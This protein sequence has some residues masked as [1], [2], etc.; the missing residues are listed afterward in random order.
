MHGLALLLEAPR[1]VRLSR[2]ALKT[3]TPWFVAS[4]LAGNAARGRFAVDSPVETAGSATRFV[5]EGL[6]PATTWS[7]S[8]VYRPLAERRWRTS[9]P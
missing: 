7:G 2:I 5:L 6:T 8:C 3:S 9:P 4:V 1:A